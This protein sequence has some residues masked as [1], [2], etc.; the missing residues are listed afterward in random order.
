MPPCTWMVSVATWLNAAEQTACAMLAA[1]A[2]IVGSVGQRPDRVVRRRSGV[3]D[4][5]QQIRQ[6][7]L[8]RLE[9]SDGPAELQPR[10]R[11]LDRQVEQML[12]G[13]DLLDGQQ[14]RADLQRMVEHA[15]R[16]VGPGDQRAPARRR[17]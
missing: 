6:P 11:V 16:L 13:A 10:L 8:D 12:G 15:R 1:N 7:V 4:I 5:D 17:T 14:R 2:G 3:L 9:R